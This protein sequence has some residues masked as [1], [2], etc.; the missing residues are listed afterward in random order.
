MR[1]CWRLGA[2][3]EL[4]SLQQAEGHC[5]RLG[6]TVK[7]WGTSVNAEGSQVAYGHCGTLWE[8]GVT[9]KARKH[10]GKLGTCNWLEARKKEGHILALNH[11][12]VAENHSTGTVVLNLSKTLQKIRGM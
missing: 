8:V 1:H 6:G 7:G 4:D 3:C 9:M 5:G 12:P 2:Q 11:G 10:C